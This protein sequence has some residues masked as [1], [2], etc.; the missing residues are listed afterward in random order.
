MICQAHALVHQGVCP[1]CR[2]I[3]EKDEEIARLEE[4][5]DMLQG[6][7]DKYLQTLDSSR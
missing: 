7:V 6:T 4:K 1:V 5:I 3:A 2:V